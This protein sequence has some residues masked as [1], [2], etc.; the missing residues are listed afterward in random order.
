MSPDLTIGGSGDLVL[1][2][3]NYLFR[4]NLLKHESSNFDF[5]VEAAV[6]EFQQS[7]GLNVTGVVDAIT[8][9]AL[10]EARWKLG[11]R[12]LSL[13]SPMMRG[14]DIASLQSQLSEMG[15]NRGKVDG[16]FGVDSESAVKEFQK[17][18]GVKIDGRC[19][20]ATIMSMMRLKKMIKLKCKLFK[21]YAI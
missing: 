9:R 14:D 18:V 19:G 8:L 20:P 15:F 10:D 5:S 1:Q 21:V 7:R 11:D 16:I 6:K 4:L 2:V 3:T 12:V 13:I 17:S